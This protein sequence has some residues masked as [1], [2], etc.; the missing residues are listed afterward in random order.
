[1]KYLHCKSY[2]HFFSLL[3]TCAVGLGFMYLMAG[4]VPEAQPPR[5]VIKPEPPPAEVPLPLPPDEDT[6]RYHTQL[7]H[8]LSKDE[9]KLVLD[10]PLRIAAKA[11]YVRDEA[12]S[13]LLTEQVEKE[14]VLAVLQQAKR[15]PEETSVLSTSDFHP[16]TLT[17]FYQEGYGSL[18]IFGGYIRGNKKPVT[19]IQDNANRLYQADEAAAE[20]LFQLVRPEIRSLGVSR[21]NIYNTKHFRKNS[22]L[23][24]ISEEKGFEPFLLMVNSLEKQGVPDLGAP[25]YLVTGVGSG[26]DAEEMFFLWTD[27]KQVLLSFA[28]EPSVIYKSQGL[29]S[30]AF[31]KLVKT[32]SVK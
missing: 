10:L 17:L 28:D 32:Y 6:I 20:K 18:Y 4:P 15:L 16:V 2:R 24:Q 22:L 21:L 11:E 1:M 7:T 9:D 31:K 29:T 5:P 14:A 26:P 27:E 12:F 19:L 13:V 30:K 3:F 8:S 25:D 23:A